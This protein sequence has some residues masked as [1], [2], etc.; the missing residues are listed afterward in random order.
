MM[1]SSFSAFAC[2]VLLGA[3][4]APNLF[5][6]TPN[7]AYIAAFPPVEKVLAAEQTA[8]PDQ[9]AAQQMAAFTWLMNMIVQMAGPRQFIRGAGGMT[10][11]ENNPRLAYNTAL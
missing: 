5:P 10:P 8:D 7:P 1:K 6:Q 11:D 4:I 9:T 2:A 3:L